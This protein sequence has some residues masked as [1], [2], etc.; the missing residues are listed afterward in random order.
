MHSGVSILEAWQSDKGRPL[1]ANNPTSTLKSDLVEDYIVPIFH[2]L[3]TSTQ[4]RL[5]MDL[6]RSFLFIL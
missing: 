4:D 5:S 2:R 1:D 6:H 3:K